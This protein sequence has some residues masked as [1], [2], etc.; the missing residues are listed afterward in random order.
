MPL[1]SGSK[2]PSA[3]EPNNS[4][5]CTPKRRQRSATAGR[6]CSMAGIMVFSW[7]NYAGN[8]S[9]MPNEPTD[10]VFI[11]QEAISFE[12]NL[13]SQPVTSS[14]RRRKQLVDQI[15]CRPECA[16]QIRV[17]EDLALGW[18]IAEGSEQIR[19]ALRVSCSPAASRGAALATTGHQIH[20]VF[21]NLWSFKTNSL[22]TL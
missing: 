3:A 8:P 11:W 17:Q 10:Q 6:V 20:C 2:R 16:A 4:R 7:G 9:R 19:L 22:K 18:R 13:K 21:W 12:A 1:R 15:S 14:R 5:L